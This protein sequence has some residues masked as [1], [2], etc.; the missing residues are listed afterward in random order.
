[1]S[2]VNAVSWRDLGGASWFGDDAVQARVRAWLFFSLVVCFGGILAA[3]WVAS[4]HWFQQKP[5]YDWPGLALILQNITLFVSAMLFRF[6]KPFD[7]HAYA[8][9]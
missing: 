1:M 8:S 4:V 6:A 3:V 2:R 5:T 9:L 7:E